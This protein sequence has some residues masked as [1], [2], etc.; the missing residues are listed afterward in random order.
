M[1]KVWRS[2]ML[3]ATRTLEKKVLEE[4][5]EKGYVLVKG[6]VPPEM[7]EAIR[8]EIVGIH[9]RCAEETPEGVGVTW[10]NLPNGEKVIRQL[11]GSQHVSE[12][13]RGL[14]ED[15]PLRQA[16]SEL[17]GEE[18][19]NFHSKLMMKK[20]GRGSFTPWHSDWG[21]WKKTFTR[22]CQMNAFLAIDRSTLENGCIRYVPGSHKEYIEHESNPN[23]HGFGIGLPGGLDAFDHEP[24]EM[25]P[26]DVAFH[27]SLTI[28]ASEANNSDRDR[29]MNTFAFTAKDTFL[30]S[31]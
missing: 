22:P 3:S 21:Y 31:K 9:E 6:L 17:L 24:I 27:G 28:H 2:R 1:S 18:I 10:E 4:Y 25:E 5:E 7:I 19:E 20:A 15:S 26:G 8:D 13:I 12:T 29:V 11:M 30:H 14:Y 23:A 16:A